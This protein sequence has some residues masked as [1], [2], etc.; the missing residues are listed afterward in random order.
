M[1]DKNIGTRK[2][3]LV[4]LNIYW[5]HIGSTKKSDYSYFSTENPN[6]IPQI[7]VSSKITV[8]IRVNL[9]L[10]NKVKFDCKVQ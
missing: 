2:S 8:K 1:K 5:L 6:S 4:P 7:E 10:G 9:T 3:N